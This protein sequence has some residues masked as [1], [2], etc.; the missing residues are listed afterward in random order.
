LA[1][2]GSRRAQLDFVFENLPIGA[3]GVEIYGVG[4]F[5]YLASYRAFEENIDVHGVVSTG[6]TTKATLEAVPGL[7]PLM[8]ISIGFGHGSSSRA[9]ARVAGAIT[10]GHHPQIRSSSHA[11]Q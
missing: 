4:A 8:Q 1:A 11:H 6:T 9:R 10:K 5:T 2:V 3:G 7:P